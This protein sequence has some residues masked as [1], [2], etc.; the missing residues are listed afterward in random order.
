MTRYIV[1]LSILVLSIL[2]L[3]ILV[4]SILVLSICLHKSTDAIRPENIILI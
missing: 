1:S 4:L 2:V 3:S